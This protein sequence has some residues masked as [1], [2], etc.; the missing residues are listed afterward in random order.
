MLDLNADNKTSFLGDRSPYTLRFPRA[1]V[2]PPCAYAL[3]GLTD[4]FSPA[5]VFVYTGC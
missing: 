5:G 1:A 4:A 3:R 2:E